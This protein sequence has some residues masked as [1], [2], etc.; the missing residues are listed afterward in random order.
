MSLGR[1]R[2]SRVMQFGSGPLHQNVQY[3]SPNKPARFPGSRPVIVLN[4]NGEIRFT[5]K[6]MKLAAG[7]TAWTFNIAGFKQP[8]KK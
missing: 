8:Q 1:Q 4:I 6:E 7:F 2:A 3:S 5:I